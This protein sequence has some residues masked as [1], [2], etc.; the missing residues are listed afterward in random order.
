MDLTASD[1]LDRGGEGKV[2]EDLRRECAGNLSSRRQR[3]K[4][5]LTPYVVERLVEDVVSYKRNEA[6]HMH[7]EEMFAPFTDD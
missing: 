5:E 7:V 6:L 3:K 1:P 2:P 4:D